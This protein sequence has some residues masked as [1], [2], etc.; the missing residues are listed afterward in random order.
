MTAECLDDGVDDD[1][2]VTA[3]LREQNRL[4]RE[5]QDARRR[6]A[7]T[8]KI[9]ALVMAVLLVIAIP[10]G[11]KLRNDAQDEASKDKMACEMTQMIMGMSAAEAREYCR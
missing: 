3:L 8:W 10:V 6:R 5:Q 1:L 2:D 11:I 4:L 9:T 7:R